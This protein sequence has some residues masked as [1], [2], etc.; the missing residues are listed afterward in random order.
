MFD[1][2]EAN[3]DL[4]CQYN[5]TYKAYYDGIELHL[6]ELTRLIKFNPADR[7]FKITPQLNDQDQRFNIT[8]VGTLSDL[9]T[10][11]TLEFLLVIS[12]A[13]E[14]KSE[15]DL[16]SNTTAIADE[17]NGYNYAKNLYNK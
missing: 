2:W 8:L 13:D 4:N 1:E 15:L 11:D 17:D 12:P 9:Y 7:E 5:W 6:S 16:E 3:G 10:T 14:F